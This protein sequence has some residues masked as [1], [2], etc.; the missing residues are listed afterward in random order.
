MSATVNPAP[1]KTEPGFEA[2]LALLKVAGD[3]AAHAQRLKELDAKIKQDSD[4]LSKAGVETQKAEAIK[5]EATALHVAVTKSKQDQAVKEKDLSDR[6]Q[7]LMSHVA[8]LAKREALIEANK[9][10]LEASAADIEKRKQVVAKAEAA[11]AGKI[12]NDQ[13]VATKQLAD[14]EAALNTAHKARMDVL[15][16]QEKDML[17]ATKAATDKLAM[18]EQRRIEYEDKIAKLKT[19]IGN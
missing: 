13:E 4:I 18:A 2:A 7:A 3:P 12:A 19:L 1:D 9:Q 14:K 16:K 15:A 8:D 17:A 11:S 10:T 5:K 6:E